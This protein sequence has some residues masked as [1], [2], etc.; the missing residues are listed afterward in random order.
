MEYRV[1]FLTDNI[2][3]FTY[4]YKI[5]CIGKQISRNSTNNETTRYF[6]ISHGKKFQVTENVINRN[7]FVITVEEVDDFLLN[8]HFNSLIFIRNIEHGIKKTTVEENSDMAYHKDGFYIFRNIVMRNG[9][10][11]IGGIVDLYE[12]EACPFNELKNIIEK[13]IA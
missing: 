7:R 3:D 2:F 9:Y 8:E 5:N 11:Y 6:F 10:P 4:P 1:E 12:F 13:G